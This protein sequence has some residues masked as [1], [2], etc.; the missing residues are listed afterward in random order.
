MSLE[1]DL[2]KLFKKLLRENHSGDVH[3]YA[4]DELVAT[5][6]PVEK[7]EDSEKDSEGE[8]E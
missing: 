1:R 2:N 8:D 4:D 6:Q 5:I 7:N 3:L